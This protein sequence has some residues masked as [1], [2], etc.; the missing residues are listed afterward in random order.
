METPSLFELQIDGESTGFLS[1]ISRWAKFLAITGFVMC[2]FMLIISL[3]IIAAG[4]SNPFMQSAMQTAGY[5][6][7]VLGVTYL[8]LAAISIIPYVY[9]YQFA[10]KMKIALR[11]SDQDVLNSSFSSLKST[12]KF[13]G[14]LTIIM[15]GFIALAFVF[16]IIAGLSSVA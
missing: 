13:V 4:N 1:E 6:P 16:G 8:V 15:L 11:S 7:T 2:G 3:F 5:N 10:S 14:V 12:F 9:L